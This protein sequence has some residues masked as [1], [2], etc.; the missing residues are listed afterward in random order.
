MWTREQVRNH[1]YVAGLLDATMNRTFQ[2]IKFQSQ[3]R[4]VTEFE[5]QEF[6][7]EQFRK[8][9]LKCSDTFPRPVVAF[10]EN[11]AEL[12][13]FPSQNKAK[14][15]EPNIVVLVDIFGRHKTKGSPFADITWT[16]Y[17]GKYIPRKVSRVFTAVIEARDA[18]IKFVRQELNKK[19]IPTGKEV[20][21]L[22]RKII[23]DAGFEEFIDHELG[24]LL[25]TYSPH[26]RGRWLAEYDD[27]PLEPGFGYTIEPGVYIEG[28]FG[29]RSEMDFFIS[30]DLK[31][32]AT[33]RLQEKLV[34]IY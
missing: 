27:K 10:G 19:H 12:H 2:H 5:I 3:K 30:R 9:K 15:L 7:L 11:S 24:H 14:K 4:G 20:D 32:E 34:R 16:G 8:W 18:C 6:I 31:F 26:G 21:A 13:H 17:Y 28:E 23:G 22:M 1:R 33:T 25:G 29:I